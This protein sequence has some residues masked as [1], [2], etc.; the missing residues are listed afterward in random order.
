MLID[1]GNDA[2]SGRA[3]VGFAAVPAATFRPHRFE[4][5]DNLVDAVGQKAGERQ[6]PESVEKLQL[7]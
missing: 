2:G 6:K 5:L 1:K 7:L 3:V 4:G